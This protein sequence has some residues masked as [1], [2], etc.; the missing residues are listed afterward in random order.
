[1]S[2]NTQS[3]RQKFPSGPE[4]QRRTRPSR[5]SPSALLGSLSTLWQQQASGGKH[6]P[7]AIEDGGAELLLQKCGKK[8]CDIFLLQCQPP[9]PSCLGQ[10]EIFPVAFS[11]LTGAVGWNL[12]L[13]QVCSLSESHRPSCFLDYQVAF[14]RV[15]S[16]GPRS[17]ILS[18]LTASSFLESWAENI[19]LTP[20]IGDIEKQ[21]GTGSGA[22]SM[23][24]MCCLR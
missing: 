18:T 10:R 3:P 19:S 24:S 21:P 12:R 4:A 20:A 7:Q 14:Y 6:R 13:C 23:Q 5:W 15:R 8:S 22:F 2:Q 17:S 1:M 9:Q 16:S 11:A